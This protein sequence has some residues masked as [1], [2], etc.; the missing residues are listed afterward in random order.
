MN[1]NKLIKRILQA[2]ISEKQCTEICEKYGYN[3]VARKLTVK[4]LFQ[5]FLLS[6][7]LESKSYRE[8]CLQGEAYGLPKVDYST[9]SKKAKEVPYEVFLE[10]FYIIFS[11][12]NRKSRRKIASK[13]GRVLKAVDST[14]IVKDQTKWSWSYY[15]QEK[16]GI[17]FHLGYYPESD[18]PVQIIPS[19]INVQDSERLECFAEEDTLLLCDRGYVNIKKM[20]ELDMQG[21][22]FI[23]RIREGINQLHVAEF[24]I[25][26]NEKYKDHICTLGKSSEIAKEY[27]KHQFRVVNFTI[28]SGERVCL[29]TNIVDL[30]ADEIADIYRQRWSIETFFKTLKQ[31]FTIKTIFGTSKN[32]AF[33]QGIIAFIAYLV[34]RA[35]YDT[36]SPVLYNI[37][38]FV[39]FIRSFR[40]NAS[41]LPVPKLLYFFKRCFA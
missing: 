16:S 25:A 41:A 21:Q 18:T 27:R 14:R 34:L 13:C 20:S 10:L 9:L 31:N 39:V 29:C 28:D 1:N 17:K 37:S 3:D 8:L 24:D 2:L 33:S 12:I 5:Y 7:I 30:S 35:V 15:K 26:H 22:E 36:F 11:K 6:A 19:A 40:Y 32:A 38:S 4:V 23:I